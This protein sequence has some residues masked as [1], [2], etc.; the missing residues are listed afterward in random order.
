MNVEGALRCMKFAESC[1]H[2]TLLHVSTSYVAG[3]RQGQI[4]ETV[5]PLKS[6]SGKSF[7]VEAELES[8]RKTIEKI[9]GEVQDKETITSRRRRIRDEL[10]SEGKR[11]A[12]QWGWQ[13]TYT[14]TKGMAEAL[15]VRRPTTIPWSIF[16]PAIVESAV[17]FPIPRMERGF[18]HLWTS[19]VSF[20][21]SVPL[22]SSEGRKSF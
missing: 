14:Y 15:L 21:N 5:D 7:D 19:G 13:N 17:S 8:L 4:A 10:I 22:P 9:A 2:A 12:A 16:R 3:I 20:G 18:Q 1:D 11:R 6:P